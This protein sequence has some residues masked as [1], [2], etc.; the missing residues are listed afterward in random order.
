M[1]WSHRLYQNL[2]QIEYD[3]H[4]NHVYDYVICKAPIA[5]ILFEIQKSV[6]GTAIYTPLA[7]LLAQLSQLGINNRKLL[8]VNCLKI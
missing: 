7:K 5:I 4:L 6:F 3:L 8:S 2:G 1:V